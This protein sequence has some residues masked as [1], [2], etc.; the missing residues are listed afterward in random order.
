MSIKEIAQI[1]GASPATVSRVLNNPEYR[2][3]TP[4]LRERIWKTAIEKN[5]TSNE[6]VRNLRMGKQADRHQTCYISVLMEAFRQ[7][8][9]FSR[10]TV[11]LTETGRKNICFCHFFVLFRRN[12]GEPVRTISVSGVGIFGKTV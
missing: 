9:T 10:Y 11:F 3:K 7:L 12:T 2:C 8:N 6:S 1:V 4:E 5:Y